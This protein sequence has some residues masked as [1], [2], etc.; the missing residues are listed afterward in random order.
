M[1]SFENPIRKFNPFIQEEINFHDGVYKNKDNNVEFP[2]PFDTYIRMKK[3][4]QKMLHNYHRPSEMVFIYLFCEFFK[5]DC[6]SL[7]SLSRLVEYYVENI[8]NK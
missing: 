2:L 1:D 5:I 4:S 7:R 3:H 6:L 8:Y